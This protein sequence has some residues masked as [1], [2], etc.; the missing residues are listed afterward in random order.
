MVYQFVPIQNFKNNS[1]IDRS[2]K[3][4]EIDKILYKKYKLSDDEIKYIESR[5]KPLD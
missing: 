5:I 4:D 1:D 3:V 2:K